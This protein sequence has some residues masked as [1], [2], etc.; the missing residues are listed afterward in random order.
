MKLK[1]L[2]RKE[3]LIKKVDKQIETTELVTFVWID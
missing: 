2:K 1:I 3:K